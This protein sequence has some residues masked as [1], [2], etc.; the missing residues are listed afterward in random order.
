MEYSFFGLQLCFYGED[1]AGM[2]RVKTKNESHTSKT[3]MW[4]LRA[5]SQTAKLELSVDGG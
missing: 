2:K 4:I 5:A 1:M 3:G